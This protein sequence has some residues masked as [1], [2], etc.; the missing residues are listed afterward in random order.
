MSKLLQNALY[1]PE[2]DLYL[3]S[4][5]VHDYREHVFKDFLTLAVDGGLDYCRRVGDLFK[6]DEA[7]RYIECCLQDDMPFEYIADKLLW[8]SSGVD[9]KSPMVFRPIKEWAHKPDGERHLRNIL[10]NCPKINL[11]HKKVVEYWL[12]RLE[13]E[14][15]QVQQ[16][17]NSQS[18]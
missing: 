5:H 16:P 15:I 8:G 17:L 3:I 14:K 10:L 2:N 18:L 11:Y 12:A 1:I 13:E 6:L 7:G 4:T 9:G